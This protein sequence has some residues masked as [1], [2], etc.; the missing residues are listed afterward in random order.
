MKYRRAWAQICEISRSEFNRVYQLLG[1]HLEEKVCKLF[2]SC[3]SRKLYTSAF[4][5]HC[6]HQ[7]GMLHLVHLTWSRLYTMMLADYSFSGNTCLA[8]WLTVLLSI[9]LD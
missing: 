9:V 5:L 4:F 7:A 8:L 2:V 1:V 3:A 6:S